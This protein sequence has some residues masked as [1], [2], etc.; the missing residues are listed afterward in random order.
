VRRPQSS[1]IGPGR[2][3]LVSWCQRL[4]LRPPACRASGRPAVGSLRSTT[5]RNVLPLSDHCLEPQ[6]CRC[7]HALAEDSGEQLLRNGDSGTH[8]LDA[9]VS[10][11]GRIGREWN[12][13]KR[14]RLMAKVT[15]GEPV[16]SNPAIAPFW[17]N[18]MLVGQSFRAWCRRF[19]TTPSGYSGAGALPMQPERRWRAG[20]DRRPAPQEVE[21]QQ[22]RP[23]CDDRAVP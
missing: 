20:T 15:M 3:L 19:E 14:S 7:S 1:S 21:A 9:V 17:H 5:R 4:G 11:F 16:R 23:D 22:C 18:M 6:G 13:G 12:V 2:R 8:F 10:C